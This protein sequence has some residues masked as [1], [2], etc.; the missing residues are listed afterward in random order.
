MDGGGRL[1]RHLPAGRAAR[2]ACES[3][4]RDIAAEAGPALG[5]RGG[6]RGRRRAE[7]GLEPRQGPCRP[8]P[9][10]SLELRPA[11]LDQR[12]ERC[13]PRVGGVGRQ[14]TVGDPGRLEGG[15]DPLGLGRAEIVQEAPAGA[16]SDPCKGRAQEARGGTTI[17][18]G[19]AAG[20]GGAAPA[21]RRPG[22]PQWWSRRSTPCGRPHG[23]PGGD[24]HAGDH[25]LEAERAAWERRSQASAVPM[26]RQ[27]AD[28]PSPQALGS[29]D[30]SGG[31]AGTLPTARWPGAARRG[32]GSGSGGCRSRSHPGRSGAAGRAR[33]GRPAKRR[34]RPRCPR[35]P[36]RARAAPRMKPSCGFPFG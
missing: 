20:P 29:G 23:D 15:A 6:D 12:G 21:R 28:H 26:I 9:Q 14:V 17:A 35:D 36:A 5:V 27:Q 2:A 19:R 4:G 11:G 25:A 8:D 18:S 7:L 16:S 32:H 1:H 24:A 31:P 22:T 13:S 34:G 30:P 33:P 3:V 10:P